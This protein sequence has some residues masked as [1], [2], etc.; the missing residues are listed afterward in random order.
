MTSTPVARRRRA[1][2]AIARSALGLMAALPAG[3][4]LAQ[5]PTQVGGVEVT[6]AETPDYKVDTNSISKLTQ[7]ALDTPQQIES[8]SHQL[9][10]DRGALSLNDALRNASGVSLGAGESSWQG[11]NLTLRGF[12]ARNDMY[13]DGMRDF[14]SYYRDPFNLEEVQVLEGPSSVLFGRGSTGGAVNQVS[15]TPTLMGHT[16]LEA[17]IGTDNTHRGTID[18]DAPLTQLGQGAAVRVN[19]MAHENNIAGFS[20]IPHFFRWG[21]APSLALGLGTPT[22]LTFSYFHQSEDDVPTQGIPWFQNA[23]AP[24]PR[25]NFYGFSSDFLHTTTD[26]WTARAEHDYGSNLTVSDQLR[27]GQY[28]HSWR[29]VEAQPATVTASTTLANETVTRALQGANS[30]E[31]FLQNQLD[32]QARFAT[33]GFKHTLVFGTEFGPERSSPEY[34]NGLGVPSTLLLTPNQNQPFAGTVFPRII[35]DTKAFT[36]AFYGIDTIEIT[37][38]LLLTGGIRWDSFQNN[39]TSTTY[40]TTLGKLGVPIAGQPVVDN[41]TDQAPSYRGGI[42]YKPTPNG[43]VYFD[44]STSFNPS[45]EALSEVV[46]VRSLNMGNLYLD[47]EKNETYEAGV[48]WNV[49]DDKVLLQGAVFREEKD[50]ARVPSAIAGLNMLGGDFRVDGFELQ[51]SGH[52]TP[53]WQF[54]ASY[55]YLHSQVIKT[56]P[57]G[58]R[59]GGRLFNAPDS[60]ANLW[61]SYA[62]TKQLEI[63]AGVDYVGLR[64][65]ND[66]EIAP[67]YATFDAM[68]KYRINAHLR[69]QVNV[70]NIGD[71]N[72]ADA[73]HGFHVIPGAGRSA[74][75]S[76]AADF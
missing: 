35:T 3:A 16:E 51:G 27:Y 59:L 21:V 13:L 29:Q 32:A 25:S 26:M 60:S 5:A 67:G 73:L 75:F 71:R 55:T 6:G 64:Y 11:T 24:V 53:E 23:P 50:N 46:A 18:F 44:Y 38:Q 58:P 52:L 74:L 34:D 76:L 47:P 54:N 66:T 37:K 69:A 14:G 62:L 39:Y 42:V 8:I 48:K 65:G 4:A 7:P 10:Q 57:G 28:F 19:L 40:N 2:P 43:S 31:T 63:G 15:K 9:I 72:Y 12:N 22:R 45:A 17:Q 33:A 68:L 36:Y 20:S 49:L 41:R 61:T 1:K 70:Y 56:A 30:N